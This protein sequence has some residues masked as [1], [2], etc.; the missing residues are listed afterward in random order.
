[1]ATYLIFTFLVLGALYLGFRVF[2]VRYLRFRGTRVVTCPETEQPAAVK[3]ALAATFDEP[4][5][6]L[7]ECTRWPERRNCGQECLKQIEAAPEDCLVRTI[8]TKWYQGK[9]C[10]YCRKPLGTINW[11]EHKPALLSPE[12]NTVE[13]QD[14]RPETIPGVLATHRPVCWNC[15]IAETFRREHPELIVDRDF[16]GGESRSAGPKLNG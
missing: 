6:R 13:W 12:R 7:K 4:H 14:L 16:I 2:G 15:H 5:L 9:S 1:M 3:V 8:L 11:L 10:I